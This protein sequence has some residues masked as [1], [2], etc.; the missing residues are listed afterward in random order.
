MES[1]ALVEQMIH[2]SNIKRDHRKY[3]MLLDW[4]EYLSLNMVATRVAVDVQMVLVNASKFLKA[5]PEIGNIFIKFAALMDPSEDPKKMLANL[6]KEAE[7]DIAPYLTGEEYVQTFKQHHKNVQDVV[8]RGD[9]DEEVQELIASLEID[10]DGSKI[11]PAQ[12]PNDPNGL[13]CVISQKFCL[14]EY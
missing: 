8:Y 14:I 3:L 10:T 4:M 9:L 11:Q 7:K 5:Y 12:N 13:W 6:H 2:T 1:A